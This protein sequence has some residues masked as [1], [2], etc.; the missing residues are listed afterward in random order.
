MS[1]IRSK[2]AV[3]ASCP[4][5]GQRVPNPYGLSSEELAGACFEVD[6]AREPQSIGEVV[7]ELIAG[8]QR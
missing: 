8:W 5:C 1:N 2:A 4:A 3:W 7:D 6:P